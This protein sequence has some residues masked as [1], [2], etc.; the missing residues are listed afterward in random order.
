MPRILFAGF[1]GQGI[2]FAGKVTANA[3]LLEHKQVTWLPS[4]G[5]EMRGGTCNCSVCID[6]EPIGCPMV[7]DPEILVVMNQPSYDKFVK[8]VQPGGKIVYD[9]FLISHA[10]EN[11]QVEQYPIPATELA[12]EH[13][14]EGLANIVA[15]G[16]LLKVSEF[17][18]KDSVTQ[19][20]DRC[21]PSSKAF[22]VEKNI[23]ALQLGIHYT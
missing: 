21:V 18:A 12:S 7:N 20:I 1:G 8:D 19:A 17:V 15:L 11:E 22:L 13:R 10:R 9:S 2:L 23:Q 14:L 6:S 4:Y 5:P 16:Y 3:G